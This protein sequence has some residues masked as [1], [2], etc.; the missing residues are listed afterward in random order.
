MGNNKIRVERAKIRISQEQL[1]EKV[2]VSRQAIHS[3]ENGKTVPG[4]TLAQKM[5]KF[6]GISTDE[7][8]PNE[9]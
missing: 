4:L 1:A 8:F 7:L 9:Q 6:F 2:N 3:I 5:A